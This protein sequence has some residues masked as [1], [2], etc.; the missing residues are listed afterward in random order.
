MDL[1]GRWA[2]LCRSSLQALGRPGASR[3][4][5]LLFR[6]CF[7]CTNTSSWLLADKRLEMS[8]KSYLGVA[9]PVQL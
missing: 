7:S 2:G 1:R 6:G 4:F 9:K 8:K 3:V 5:L